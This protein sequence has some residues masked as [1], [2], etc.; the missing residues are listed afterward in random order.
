MGPTGRAPRPPG[1]PHLLPPVPGQA[2]GRGAREVSWPGQGRVRVSAGTHPALPPP[3]PA[4]QAARTHGVNAE[5]VGSQEDTGDIGVQGEKW[6]LRQ[7]RVTVATGAGGQGLRGQGGHGAAAGP[8]LQSDW[9]AMAATL[10]PEEKM[11]V[12]RLKHSL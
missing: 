6:V 4:W 2:L 5:G 8:H 9:V 12:A 3:A 11:V 1:A 10:Q 7:E